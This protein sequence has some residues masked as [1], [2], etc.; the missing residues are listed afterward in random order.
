MGRIK[1]W[2]PLMLAL[3]CMAA[4]TASPVYGAPAGRQ[5]LKATFAGSS[6]GGVWYM[7][8]SGVTEAIS[9]SFP[10]SSITVIPGEGV[11][12]LT[13]VARN[14]A[15]IGL[16]HSAVAAAAIM[17]KD[18][19]KERFENVATIAS[20]YPS[21]LQFVVTK[22]SGVRSIDEI[23]AKKPRIRI[24]VDSP[25][26]TGELAF[27]RMIAEYGLTYEAIRKWGGEVLFKNMGDS[28]D[29]VSD[30]RLDGF[31]TM[32]LSPASPLQ[33]ASLN[34]E[35]V[36][37][38]IKQTVIDQL[39]QKYGYGR[40]VIAPKTY[41]FSA[42]EVPSITSYTVVIVSRDAPEALGYS[43]ALSI[44]ENLDYLKSVHVAM[45]DL[46]AAKLIQNL[47]APLHRGAER[48]YRE[49]GLLKSPA[50]AH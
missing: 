40:G 39:V 16:T 6:P 18:P 27:K 30:G 23:V 44:R 15:Q 48:Y 32:T 4:L 7:V 42:A 17:G 19:F 33:E 12:N 46:T 47:G 43:V 24:S 29:M 1:A 35:L 31:S 50:K 38:P 14:Q 26:S 41:K 49:I 8:M 34:N 37:L 2:F 11:S 25:G 20:L 22:K 13:R 45:K 3:L 9:K 28:S 36:L 10:G 5:P 21:L